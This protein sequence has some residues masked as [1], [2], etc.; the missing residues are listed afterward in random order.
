M[1]RRRFGGQQIF[2]ALKQAEAG[3]GLRDLCRQLGISRKMFYS[4]RANYGETTV[5]GAKRP[6]QIED[7]NRRLNRLVADLS[8]SKQA[9]TAQRSEAALHSV[10]QA[11]RGLLGRE[12]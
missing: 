9:L 5:S 10:R 8:L 11:D 3:V 12:L 1:R 6:R 2:G 4:W 7:E